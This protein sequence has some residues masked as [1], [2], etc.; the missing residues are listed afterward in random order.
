MTAAATDRMIRDRFGWAPGRPALRRASNSSITGSVRVSGEVGAV[1]SDA[2]VPPGTRSSRGGRLSAIRPQSAGGGAS[3]GTSSDTTTSNDAATAVDLGPGG[4]VGGEVG[5]DPG[6]L[7]VVEGVEHVRAEQAVEV[8]GAGVDL[9]EI[10]AVGHDRAP[11]PVASSLSA[12]LFR[13]RR[14]RL[15]IVPSGRS[16]MTA[17][18]R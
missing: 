8:V 6:A 14:M 4:R 17:T 2:E 15:L 13:P 7:G 1:A 3:S 10:V 5:L 18:S 11:S 12:S 9:L 16:S